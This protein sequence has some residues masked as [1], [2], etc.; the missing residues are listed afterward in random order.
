MIFLQLF[1]PKWN[2]NVPRFAANLSFSPLE[3]TRV[4]SSEQKVSP[5]S[6]Q[7]NSKN[8]TITEVDLFF[9]IHKF[10]IKITSLCL[11]RKYRLLNSTGTVPD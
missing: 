8:S 2:P 10:C 11:F 7:D 3:P 4:L 5:T 1:G 9:L 6:P